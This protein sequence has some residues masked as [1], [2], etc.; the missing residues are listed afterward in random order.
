MLLLKFYRAT[1]REPLNFALVRWYDVSDEDE[2]LWG[3]PRLKQ[4]EQY[5]CIPI[6]SVDKTVH[7]VPKFG[8]GRRGN[9]F[10]VNSFMF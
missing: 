8:R 4:T 5:S 7:I 2:E 9:E 6:E 3:C 1:G 10:L